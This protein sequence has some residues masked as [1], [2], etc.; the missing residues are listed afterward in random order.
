M[1]LFTLLLISLLCW[2][3]ADPESEPEPAVEP[4][5]PVVPEAVSCSLYFTGDAM[6]HQ[7]QIDTALQADG[8]YSYVQYFS[9][10]EP[11]IKAADFAVCN[12]ESVLA[13]KPYSG[14]PRFSAP[15]EFASALKDAGFDICLTANNHI[16]DKGK[17]GLLRTLDV[18][19]EMGIDYVGTYRC[20]TERDSL[21]PY[22]IDHKG[23]KIAL[24]NYTYGT[25]GHPVPAP[26]I[27]NLIDTVQ[28]AADI[29]KAR[30]ELEA[31]CIIACMHWGTEYQL[32]PNSTQKNLEKWLYAHGV[33]HIIG[34]HPHVVQPVRTLPYDGYAGEHL[35]AWSLGN[36]VS[37]QFFPNTSD[38]LAITMDLFHTGD[39]TRL[40]SYTRH[41]HQVQ[42]P[43]YVIKPLDPTRV[44]L[45]EE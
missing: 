31:D 24:L 4:A 37:N 43:Y 17:A 34:S 1:S 41:P 40:I 14:F 38:G 22:I 28:I 27:V 6:Q 11:E 39:V 36:T 42:K 8:T 18:F 5:V 23:F 12:F 32:E 13:G 26:V 3:T 44:T 2:H 15:D 16:L 25:N 9:L 30:H 45:G 29:L 33:D 19:D 21:Y 20:Q 7:A 10:I 35:T